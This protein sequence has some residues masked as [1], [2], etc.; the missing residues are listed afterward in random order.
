VLAR[1]WDAP[2]QAANCE[3]FCGDALSVIGKLC[4]CTEKACPLSPDAGPPLCAPGKPVSC[5]S[6]QMG[7]LKCNANGVGTSTVSCA[8]FHC[9]DT[10]HVCDA[11]KDMPPTWMEAYLVRC[12]ENGMTEKVFCERGCSNGACL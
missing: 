10:S 6:D 3:K 12:D 7:F 1:S 5:T 8:P 9:D 11:C 4:A 2:Y